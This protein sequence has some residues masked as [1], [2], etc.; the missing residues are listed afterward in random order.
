M[1]DTATKQ[2]GVV[3]T[4]GFTGKECLR[5]LENHPLANVAC[6]MSA[7]REPAEPQ[8]YAGALREPACEPFAADKLHGLDAVFVCAPHETAALAVPELLEHVP[9]VID[10]SA[11][12]RLRDP[13]LYDSHY[14]FRHPH[15]EL[16][17][18]A[19]FGLTEWSRE[20]L[21]R[22]RLIANP[23]CY[24]T[25]VLLPLMA[26]RDGG[27]IATGSDMI[28]DCK[29]GVSGAG[30]GA[31]PVTH[32]ASVN[33]DFR[34]YGVGTHRHEPEMRQELGTERLFFSPH[35]L[36]V[37]RGILSTIHVK[38]TDGMTADDLRGV[39][40]ERYTNEPFVRVYAVDEGWP[41][42]A[43]VQLTNACHIGVAAHGDRVVVVSCLDNLIKGAAGQAV[44]NFN[45]AVGIDETLGLPTSSET[46]RGWR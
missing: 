8:G 34:A 16:L 27:C 37:F 43:D 45:V 2:V 22:A 42:L 41:T 4:S 12:Y 29:S 10:L 35:L 30:K 6:T 31:T 15:A 1:T 38:P 32:F 14:R 26:L 39:L 33:E 44:Q 11:A 40:S 17:E 25:S 36:P 19:V 21:K 13:S 3:G 28:A 9:S 20:R 46:L 7:R 18:T 5:L 24:V 23:G